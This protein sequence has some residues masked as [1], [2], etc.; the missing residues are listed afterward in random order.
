[1]SQEAFVQHFEELISEK[2]KK[3]ALLDDQL[4]EDLGLGRRAP[5]GPEEPSGPAGSA[6]E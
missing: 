1:M 6:E 2:N 3:R 4:L 5:E